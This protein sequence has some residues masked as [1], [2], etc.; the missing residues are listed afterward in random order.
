MSKQGRNKSTGGGKKNPILWSPATL[1]SHHGLQE[2]A[3]RMFAAAAREVPARRPLCMA[4]LDW[5]EYGIFVS[6]GVACWFGYPEAV[7]CHLH[8]CE[9]CTL[10]PLSFKGEDMLAK[11]RAIDVWQS[12]R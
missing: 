2:I 1:L 3:A 6:D 7:D 11:S 9:N 12:I 5:K 4:S 8:S 10:F